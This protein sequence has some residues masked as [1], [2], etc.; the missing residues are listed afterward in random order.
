MKREVISQRSRL[1]RLWGWRAT[2]ILCAVVAVV[3]FG[4]IAGSQAFA[5]SGPMYVTSDTTLTEDHYGTIFVGAENVALDCAGH[6]V[7][8]EGVGVGIYL[9]ANGVTV[10]NCTV[11]SFATGIQTD[12]RGARIITNTLN[13]NGEG[14][15]L[16]GATGATVSGNTANNNDF[17]GILACCKASDNTISDNQTKENRVVGMTLNDASSNRVTGNVSVHNGSGFGIG[18]GSALNTVSHNVAA[19]NIRS[20]FDF[21]LADNNTIDRNVSVNN[22]SGPN[23][24][25]FSFGPANGNTVTNNVAMHNGSTGF[26]VFFASEL[27][28]F[29]GNHACQNFFGD[30]FDSSTGAGNIWSD[31]HFCNSL[32]P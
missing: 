29:S 19:N 9:G 20:G 8:G 21:A 1:H 10:T 15:R 28:L 2:T 7:I 3:A 27:N 18:L 25:G 11:E 22:G 4:L 31:N 5:S 17:W 16:G 14:L 24:G 13:H 30:A 23:G 32:L 6:A 12:A 26:N